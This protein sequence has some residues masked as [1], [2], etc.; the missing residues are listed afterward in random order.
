MRI[1][2]RSSAFIAGWALFFLVSVAWSSGDGD[3]NIGIGLLAFGLVALAAAVWG[4]YDGRRLDF[5]AL[6][7]T[8]GL[9]GVLMGLIV[10][11]FTALVDDELDA[12]VLASD[13]V[14]LMPFIAGLVAGPALVAGAVGMLA[15]T[16]HAPR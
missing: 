7:V 8:W 9:V 12:R 6:A 14:V 3:A 2:I 1:L 13:I 5:G 10:P 16:R 11:V 15:G 4:W